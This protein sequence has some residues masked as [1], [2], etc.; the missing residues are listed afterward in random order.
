MHIVWHRGEVGNA[1]SGGRELLMLDWQCNDMQ[2]LGSQR[3]EA[4]DEHCKSVYYSRIEDKH[5]LANEPVWHPL[6]S[7]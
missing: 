5:G 7:Y 4:H 3:N 2:A 1:E 6:S